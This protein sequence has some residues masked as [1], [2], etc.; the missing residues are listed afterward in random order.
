MEFFSQEGRKLGSRISL[1][2]AISTITQIPIDVLR[3]YNFRDFSIEERIRWGSKRKTGLAEDKAYALLGIFGVFL[4]VNYGE[5]EEYAFNP[6][7]R[8]IASQVEP[9]DIFARTT[10][11]ATSGRYHRLLR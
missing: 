11:T 1:E 9:L 8:E 10:I 3:S 7:K 5:G 6:L 4:P 2:R